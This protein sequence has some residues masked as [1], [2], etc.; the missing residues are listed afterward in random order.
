MTDTPFIYLNDKHF[1]RQSGETSSQDDLDACLYRWVSVCL[2]EGVQH[3][4]TMVVTAPT[5]LKAEFG[6]Y[7]AMADEIEIVVQRIWTDIARKLLLAG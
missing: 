5:D 1:V 7:D 6:C 2:D 4:D 3:L